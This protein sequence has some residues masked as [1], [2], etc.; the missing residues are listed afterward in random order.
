[1]HANSAFP[2]S[3]SFDSGTLIRQTERWTDRQE[4]FYTVY[5]YLS[6]TGRSVDG[7]TD[8][9]I[10]FSSWAGRSGNGNGVGRVRSG[11]WLGMER[12]RRENKVCRY[13]ESRA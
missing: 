4:I 9:C 7:E 11:E 8:L 13:P 12:V 1:M 10:E 3:S 6:P 5:D 2:P